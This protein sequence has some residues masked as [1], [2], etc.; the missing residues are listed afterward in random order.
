[1]QAGRPDPGR[2]W[3]E[4]ARDPREPGFQ[5][6]R[7]GD[8]DRDLVSGTVSEAYAEGRLTREELDDRLNQVQR[9]RLLGD[10]LPIVS[11]L[12]PHRDVA[13]RGT[14]ARAGEQEVDRLAVDRYTEQRRRA[15]AGMLVPS[16]ICLTIWIASMVTSGQWLFPWP[17][18]VILGTGAHLTRLVIGRESAIEEER[19]KLRKKQARQLA[20][21]Q[22]GG[23]AGDGGVTESTD[24]PPASHGHGR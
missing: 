5:G 12:V 8:R 19:E 7:A 1:M 16:L 18:F 2:F 23:P 11:D 6:L 17:L 10:L 21:E 20:V 3:S 9:A 22:G 13:S 4:F 15:L 14:L 24:D